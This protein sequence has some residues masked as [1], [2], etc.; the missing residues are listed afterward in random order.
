M[1]V[2]T[3]VEWLMCCS[4]FTANEMASEG[5]SKCPS[6]KLE[7][8][9]DYINVMDNFTRWCLVWTFCKRCVC[10]L[11][12]QSAGLV[13]C[14]T[15]SSAHL[16]QLRRRHRHLEHGRDTARGERAKRRQQ[17][18]GV[19]HQSSTQTLIFTRSVNCDPLWRKK[20]KN[21]SCVFLFRLVRVLWNGSICWIN[22]WCL[23][24]LLL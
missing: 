23:L 8:L 10:S 19:W 4:F 16:L 6:S 12:W 17:T 20:W 2:H 21:L 13:L 1:T 24:F 15:H 18:D 14:L 3:C 7:P 9:S 22:R 11:Q 5:T